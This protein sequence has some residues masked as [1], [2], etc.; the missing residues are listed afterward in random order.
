MEAVDDVLEHF[1]KKG[2]R[3]GVR[4]NSSGGAGQPGSGLTYSRN[5]LAK[6]DRKFVKSVGSKATQKKVKEV[7]RYAV[8]EMNNHVQS[9]NNSPAYKGK[10]LRKPSPLRDKYIEEV[11]DTFN[12]VLDKASYNIIGTSPSGKHSVLVR[13]DDKGDP[14]WRLDTDSEDRDD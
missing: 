1:G 12:E 9:I 3:W 11:M 5:E 8:S 13:T 10:D 2:M 6:Q 7:H 4:N 14:M